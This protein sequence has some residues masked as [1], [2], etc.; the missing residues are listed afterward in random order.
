MNYQ[1]ARAVVEALASRL[2]AEDPTLDEAALVEKIK[3]LLDEEV[4]GAIA[5]HEV[6]LMVVAIED[7][8]RAVPESF[9][10]DP[11]DDPPH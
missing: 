8:M 6:G 10:D 4:V 2:M 9:P 11:R 7:A 3:G 1:E 5:A